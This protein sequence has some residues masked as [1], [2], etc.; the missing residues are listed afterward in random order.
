[1]TSAAD[2]SGDPPAS[3]ASARD[4]R[5]RPRSSTATAAAA[6]L[7][8]RN[9]GRSRRRHPPPPPPPTGGPVERRARRRSG[10]RRTPADA[11]AL[12]RDLDIVER[13][14]DAGPTASHV[15]DLPRV[16]AVANQKGGVGKTTT[17]VNLGACLAELGYRTLVVDL[18][19]QGNA[20][21]GLGHQ[22]PG[23]GR[24]DVR[25]APAGRAARGLHRR[26]LGAQPV[27]GAG[28]PRSGRR[29]DRAGAGLQPGARSCATRSTRCIDDYDFV[30][31]DCPP[32]LGL[33]T[34]NALA[35]AS[36]VLVPIQC[37]YYA[38][39]GLGQL[40]RNVELVQRNLNPRL[41]VSAIV[42]V[43]YDARTKLAD[44]VATR[45]ASTSG[46]R[47]AATWS[48]EPCGCPRRRRSVSRSSRSIRAPGGPSPTGSWPRRSAVARRSGLGKGLG[49]LIPTGD[50]WPTPTS[51]GLPEIPVS[52]DRARTSTNPGTT[53]TRRRC[54]S[55]TASVREL[56]VLQ[57]IL[58]RPAEGGELR[59]HRR[60]AALACRQAGRSADGARHRPPGRGRAS[61]W[62]R[63]WWRTCT[64]RTSTR[65][66][67]PRPTSS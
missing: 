45:S 4:R 16:I 20:S 7:A 32:S 5:S 37:E 53:S 66:R 33:L 52:R 15:R 54:V 10:R 56:G 44:Q 36:E 1:M 21:T 62:S 11:M 2:G 41:E 46:R 35:A 29:G 30:L 9:P 22:P 3:P 40:L 64:A 13:V 67:R 31:I 19:P 47:S 50:G 39:E 42:L 43:M 17:A 6:G 28:Q 51:T 12:P 55:L 65:W 24:L 60:R 27:R 38:L 14:V 48:R 49:A 8:H 57:P 23:A 59:A 26:H 18:D 58:V 63:R 25:R 61:R 34:V